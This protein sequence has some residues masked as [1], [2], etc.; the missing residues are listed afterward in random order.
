[1]TLENGG[2]NSA[3]L[4]L[5]GAADDANGKQDPKGQE[6][7][8]DK[9]ADINKRI[10]DL[11][12]LVE[13]LKKESSGKDKKIAQMLNEK[14]LTELQNKTEKEQLEIYKSKTALYERKEAYRQSGP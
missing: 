10:D 13:A 3:D 11:T 4:N 2:I 5:K 6:G 14:E 7:G 12:A 9:N 1:M 8:G